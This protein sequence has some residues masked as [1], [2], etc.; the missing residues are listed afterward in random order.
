MNPI[1]LNIKG[2]IFDGY[3]YGGYLF[4]V[5]NDG[6]FGKISMVKL[7]NKKFNSNSDTFK[8]LYLSFI[9]S[10]WLHNSQ[11][12][13][14]LTITEMQ[15]SW[16]K[17]W[18][19][20]AS[21]T[22]IEINIDKSDLDFITVLDDM[23]LL[24]IKAYN[25]RIYLGNRKGI[26]EGELYPSKNSTLLD[27]PKI[28]KLSDIRTNFINAKFGSILVSSNQEGLFFGN[29]WGN[30]GRLKIG[31]RP[32]KPSSVRT[33][34]MKYDLV[35]YETKTSL[36]YIQNKHINDKE[37]K[38]RHNQLSEEREPRKIIIE[39]FGNHI[40]DWKDLKLNIDLDTILYT[41]NDKE[42]EYFLLNNGTIE[43]RKF[44]I[45]GSDLDNVVFRQKGK[46]IST[47]KN[48]KKVLS[49]NI[50]YLNNNIGYVIEY[51]SG[52]DVLIDGNI[53]SICEMPAASVRTYP[54][55]IR[56]RNVI[57]IFH[58]EGLLLCS[59]PNFH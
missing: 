10:D 17:I 58:D 50:M 8:L 33:G 23:P 28:E 22:P 18:T 5:M 16:Y 57:S 24:D 2:D 55:S 31:E 27:L 20:Q 13:M 19:A 37:G 9:H 39:E 15:K 7:I 29:L 25:M 48:Y 26:Y 43:G 47:K 54:N 38:Y 34:W 6:F 36:S 3:L 32:I 44:N 40:H 56:Y 42:Y 1:K 21:E 14:L 45:T 46:R 12:E 30:N 4:A 53:T 59:F 52:V 49:T 11:A 35:N 51:N 41:F